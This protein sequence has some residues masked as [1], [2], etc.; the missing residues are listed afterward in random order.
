VN[1]YLRWLGRIDNTDWVPPAI[2]Y[3]VRNRNRPEELVRFYRD[4]ERLAFG[5]MIMRANIN[6]RIERYGL[7]LKAIESGSDLYA[8]NSPLQLTDEESS[9]VMKALD[10]DLYRVV[11]VRL[12]VLLRLDAALFEGEVHYNYPVITVEHVLPQNPDSDS[13]WVK[14]FPDEEMRDR[15]VHRLGNLVLLSRRKNAQASNFDF[16]RKKNEYFARG[17]SSP[18]SLTSQVLMESEWTP[19]VIQRRQELLLEVLKQEWRL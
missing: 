3:M 14:W 16:E 2:L 19:D 4:L 10:G 13:Q 11:K 18:F 8:V 12:L 15:Y 5:M 9:Q 17:G 7:V 1:S 6:D